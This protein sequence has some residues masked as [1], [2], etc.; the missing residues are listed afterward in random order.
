MEAHRPTPKHILGLH[1][2]IGC[3]IF[4]TALFEKKHLNPIYTLFYGIIAIS[5][6]IFMGMES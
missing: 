1:P 6:H 4:S 2:A 3:I 5:A